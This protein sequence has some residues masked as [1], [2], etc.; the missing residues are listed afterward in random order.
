[1]SYTES[2]FYLTVISCLFIYI[3][4]LLQC[5]RNGDSWSG[6][7]CEVVQYWPEDCTVKRFLEI[8][9]EYI[10]WVFTVGILCHWVCS[11]PYVC[12]HLNPWGRA[13]W[14]TSSMEQQKLS[15]LTTTAIFNS[16]RTLRYSA[17]RI[18]SFSK[19]YFYSI[20]SSFVSSTFNN[21]IW[22]NWCHD[23]IDI[24]V[25]YSWD[26][27]RSQSWLQLTS[28]DYGIGEI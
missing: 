11:I 24:N 10:A 27:V 7:T 14:F 26:S 15:M 23:V 18:Y 19:L 5:E 6:A 9:I 4:H 8:W 3:W 28:K 17:S 13:V 1:M 22:G 20:F 25:I 21:C 12:I 2:I 16:G